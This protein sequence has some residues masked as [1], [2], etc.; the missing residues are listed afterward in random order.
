MEGVNL[1]NH[2]D[3]QIELALLSCPIAALP[4]AP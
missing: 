1:A 3:K 4:F 2:L